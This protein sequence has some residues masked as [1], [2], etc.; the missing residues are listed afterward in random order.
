MKT[1]FKLYMKSASCQVLCAR[2]VYI[3]YMLCGERG[4]RGAEKAEIREN[5][6]K[7]LKKKI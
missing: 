1:V 2:R 7:F 5:A 3:I 4:E 6:E